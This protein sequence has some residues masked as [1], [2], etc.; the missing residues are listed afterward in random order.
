MS[1]KKKI[2]QQQNLYSFKIDCVFCFS[3]T[4]LC[5]NF[6]NELVDARNKWLAPNGLI[7]PDRCNMYITAID[8]ELSLDRSNY[9]Q[10]V[11]T[12]DMRPMIPAVNSEPYLKCVNL[13]RV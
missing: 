9:W 8:D 7:F 4:L 6:L 13:E 3:H 12:F 1:E 2:K 5:G 11:Y 10:H